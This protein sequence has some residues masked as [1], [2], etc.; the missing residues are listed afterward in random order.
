MAIFFPTLGHF[1]CLAETN[2]EFTTE[3]SFREF[4]NIFC[5]N[6]MSYGAKKVRHVGF[7]VH[8]KSSKSARIGSGNKLGC[9]LF[10]SA[11]KESEI[12]KNM[13]LIPGLSGRS[14]RYWSREHKYFRIYGPVYKS[15]RNR[16]FFAG[17]GYERRH[18]GA[19]VGLLWSGLG[20]Y[21]ERGLVVVCW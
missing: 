8:K 21:E 14:S 3:I 4:G 10:V 15:I 20:F 2:S 6:K 18:C 16:A 5:Q 17:G 1:F 13:F 19:R 12:K 9:L 7:Q 11:C